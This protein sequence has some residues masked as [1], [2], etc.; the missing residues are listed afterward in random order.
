MFLGFFPPRFLLQ[1]LQE[2]TA[3]LD[4]ALLELQ[5]T[6]F[7][8]RQLLKESQ[9]FLGSEYKGREVDREKEDRTLTIAA[10]EY[11]DGLCCIFTM[12][13][14]SYKLKRAVYDEI[15]ACKVSEERE[16]LCTY[17]M[18]PPCLDVKLVHHLLA[19][20]QM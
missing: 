12:Y 18:K 2:A 19:K 13:E 15:K 5:D 14:R 7:A 9:A 20:V 6:V 3:E 8:L 11:V 1:V 4:G 17:F 16:E 10:S